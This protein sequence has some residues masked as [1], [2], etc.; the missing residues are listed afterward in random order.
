MQADAADAELA[1]LLHCAV[2]A[3]ILVGSEVAYARD[4]RALLLGIN[5]YRGD[6]YRF[7][8]DLYRQA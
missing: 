2:G 1:G 7:R 8:A 5:R 4:G 3:P 6:A